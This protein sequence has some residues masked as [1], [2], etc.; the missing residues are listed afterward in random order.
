MRVP[1]IEDCLRE[2]GS[3]LQELWEETAART[4]SAFMKEK[5]RVL[6]KRLVDQDMLMMESSPSS[7]RSRGEVVHGQAT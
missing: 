5:K 7:K 2:D 1:R 4:A 3:L 6:G